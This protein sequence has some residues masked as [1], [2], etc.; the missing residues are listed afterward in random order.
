MVIHG[1]TVSV[2]Y[3]DF[4]IRGI[5][6]WRAGLDSLLVVT[7][8]KDRESWQIGMDN[9]AQVLVTDAFYEQ[10]AQW[11]K[12]RAMQQGRELMPRE[13]WNLFID[14]DVVPPANWRNFVEAQDPKRGHLY[15]AR[16]VNE[17]GKPIGDAELAGF[18]QLFHAL[19]PR[20]MKPL[21]RDFYHGGNYDSDFMLR[22]PAP[23]R[24]I[25]PLELT[26]HGE[27]GVNWCGRGNDAAMAALRARRRAGGDWRTE[28]LGVKL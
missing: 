7:D 9:N 18:F 1:L 8:T 2:N 15:G 5:A 4:L 10:G 22:W 6:A 28:K 12:G 21:A 27:P 14:A 3:G 11:N 19:D 24:R 25:L 16:R 23:L 26:H 13:D 17:A 20:A